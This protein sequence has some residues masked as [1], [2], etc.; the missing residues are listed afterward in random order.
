MMKYAVIG[1]GVSGL[2]VAQMLQKKGET[3]VVYE[4]YNRPGGMIK[5]D[6][7]QGSLFHRTG[8]HV[9]NTKRT[10]VMDWF[11]Q[12]FDK[13]REFTKALRNSVVSMEGNKIIPYPIENHAYLLDDQTLQSFIDDLVIMSKEQGVKE[14]KNFEEFLEDRFGK[15][16]Y[17]LYFR[18]YNS[19][20]WRRDLKHVP[21]SWLA[22][23]LPMPSIQEMIYYNIRQVEERAFVHSSFYYPKCG[24]SQFLADRLA[25]GLQI[26]YSSDITNIELHHGKWNVNGNEY[27]RVVF[28]GNIKNLPSY[29]SGVDISN[30]EKAIQALEYHGTTSVFCEIEK[31]PYSWIYMPSE[32]HE[33]HRIICSGNFAS[34]NNAEDKMTATIEFTDAIS[35]EEIL[36]NLSRIPFAP[37]YLTHNYEQYTYPIQD[38]NTREMV[39]SLKSVLEKHGLY[40]CGRF[41]EWEYSNMDVCMGSA[42]DLVSQIQNVK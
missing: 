37:K 12:H 33:S 4:K 15:T 25:E 27:D 13:E 1:A 20:V 34:S 30:Y 17:N 41:A 9:F 19:K 24:G 29:V 22:G 10:D 11:W 40:L 38:E 3:V 14:P 7:V 31:N 36:D 23:K 18:P 6:R 42:M 16:L 32:K 26:E 8:G 39:H 35:K 5:C 28:C 2:S 21:L